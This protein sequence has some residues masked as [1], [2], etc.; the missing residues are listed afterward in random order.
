[1]S[2][3][4][5][6]FPNFHKYGAMSLWPY[7]SPELRCNVN[8]NNDKGVEIFQFQPIY[9]L[10]R[11]IGLT[12]R[13]KPLHEIQTSLK[14]YYIKYYWPGNRRGLVVVAALMNPISYVTMNLFMDS[15]AS[16]ITTG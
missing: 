1:M 12:K 3:R 16:K 2:A 9:L 10:Y 13:L 4:L 5:L 15:E 6:G 11:S 7:G 14:D 8:D